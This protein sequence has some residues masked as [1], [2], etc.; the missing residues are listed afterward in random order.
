MEE[1]PG[2]NGG[3][4]GGGL[5]SMLT[6]ST[7]GRSLRG[8]KA[9]LDRTL[10]TLKRTVSREGHG[11]PVPGSPG[12]GQQDDASS[13]VPV[14]WFDS[15]S[16]G[17]AG[18]REGAPPRLGVIDAVGDGSS[19]K[20]RARIHRRGSSSQV[21]MPLEN[22]AKVIISHVR[23]GSLNVVPPSMMVM[24]IVMMISYLVNALDTQVGFTNT[25]F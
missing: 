25:F 15:P 20:G 11:G 5:M 4:G 6:P 2:Y 18:S 19:H 3:G 24:L 23:R 14:A 8:M 16:G 7:L 22:R 21:Y 9:E 17:D 10:H 13:R 1:D 12:E